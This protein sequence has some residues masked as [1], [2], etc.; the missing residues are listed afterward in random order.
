[1]ILKS[2]ISYGRKQTEVQVTDLGISLECPETFTTE[3]SVLKEV[4]K[5]HLNTFYGSYIKPVK[6][7]VE[8]PKGLQVMEVFEKYLDWVNKF[9][10]SVVDALKKDE[11]WSKLFVIRSDFF[12]YKDILNE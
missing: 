4:L 7:G 6:Y 8:I 12:R 1:M 3:E 9:S 2:I 11:R 5:S 10:K